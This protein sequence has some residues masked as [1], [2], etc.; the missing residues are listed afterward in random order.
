MDELLRFKAKGT[1]GINI[2]IPPTYEF[3]F[4]KEKLVIYKKDKTVM[5]VNYAEINEVAVVKN[6][7]NNVLFN[8]KS[9]SFNI[10]AISDEMCDKIKEITKK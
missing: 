10:Y 7:Q 1:I 5:E 6:W 8:C 3:V 4:Y 2:F 9:K